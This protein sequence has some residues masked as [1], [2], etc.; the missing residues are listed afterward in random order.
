MIII[1]LRSDVVVTVRSVDAH[2]LRR[3][4]KSLFKNFIQMEEFGRLNSPVRR[5]RITDDFVQVTVELT[6]DVLVRVKMGNPR[7]VFEPDIVIEI[8][9]FFRTRYKEPVV[10]KVVS[11][12]LEESGDLRFT[13]NTWLGNNLTLSKHRKM[14]VK[15]DEIT[16]DGEGHSIDLH[17][18]QTPLIYIG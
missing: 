15:G 17:D 16:I 10:E 4:S 7:I 13:S 5:D 6:S 14:Y 12:S 9:R 1:G 3:E 11:Q 2:D 18:H 8:F